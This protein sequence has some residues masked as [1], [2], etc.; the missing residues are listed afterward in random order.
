MKKILH[1][2]VLLCLAIG[3]FN[4][5]PKP[6]EITVPQHDP[7]LVVSS[8]I[9]PSPA[10][11]SIFLFVSLSNSFGALQYQQGYNEDSTGT[12]TVG[13]DLFQQLLVDSAIV[14]IRYNGVQ[15]T[16]FDLNNGLYGDWP[17]PKFVGSTYFLDIYAPTK[18]MSATSSAVL[19]EQVKFDTVILSS[20]SSN[21]IDYVGVDVEFQDPSGPNFYVLN[22]YGPADTNNL[23]A[24]GTPQSDTRTRLLTDQA[25]PNG[26]IKQGFELTEFTDSVMTV[27]VANIS[28]EYYEYLKL[29]QK[30]NQSIG[31]SFLSEPVSYPT[32]V[33]GGLGFF[34]LHFPNARTLR[35]P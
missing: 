23:S 35:V 12:D 21:S 33:N 32:N 2:T 1:I 6:L 5:V 28:R 10:S 3:M 11:D 19:M 22:F 4:C 13:Q 8:Q 14:T 34:T 24:F 20:Y 16:L 15:D 31:E 29:R 9:V 18:G 7:K 25:Y 26:V 30:S 27:S 17:I